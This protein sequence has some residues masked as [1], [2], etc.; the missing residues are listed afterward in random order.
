MAYNHIAKNQEK[1]FKNYQ[2]KKD[3]LPIGEQS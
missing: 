1:N 2:R 3:I